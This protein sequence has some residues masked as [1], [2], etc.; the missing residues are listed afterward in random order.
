[1]NK[2]A[3][4]NLTVYLLRHAHSAWARPGQRDFDRPLDV[5]GVD[6][7]NIVGAAFAR[8]E[9]L[10]A[11]VLCS[12][13]R[14][15]QQTCEIVLSHLPYKPQVQSSDELYSN[16]HAYYI[17]QLSKQSDTPVLLIGHNPMMEDT[18]RFL[19]ISAKDRPGERLQK[20]FPTAGLAVIEFEGTMSQI[21]DGGHLS[22]FLSP[23]RLRKKAQKV[24]G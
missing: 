19:S 2:H 13:A 18:A 4:T 15:C 6:D 12:T 9:K 7:A 16:D 24:E 20:G 5:R 14:R 17:E 3:S 21:R 11:T 22:E 23:K 1:M 10:P 8:F